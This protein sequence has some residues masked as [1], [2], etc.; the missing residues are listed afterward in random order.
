MLS[1][2]GQ[3]YIDKLNR[4]Y[5]DLNN[6]DHITKKILLIKLN[7]ILPIEGYEFG[8]FDFVRINCAHYDFLKFAKKSKNPGLILLM[9]SKFI[10][11]E[12]NIS[13]TYIKYNVNSNVF[14]LH[15]KII[16]TE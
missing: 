16:P 3:V 9:G 15:R 10:C 5:Q 4:V 8:I 14:T 6:T 7:E 12:F 1:A 11:K 13:D 2:D